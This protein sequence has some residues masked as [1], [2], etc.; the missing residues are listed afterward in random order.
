[1]CLLFG[2]LL[3]EGIPGHAGK[4]RSCAVHMFSRLTSAGKAMCEIDVCTR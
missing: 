1:M 4:R 3:Q 2:L